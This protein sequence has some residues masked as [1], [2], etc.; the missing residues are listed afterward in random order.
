MRFEKNMNEQNQQQ[1]QEKMFD[2]STDLYSFIALSSSSS[3]PSSLRMR[4][5]FST[6]YVSGIAFMIVV[7]LILLWIN[8]YSRQCWCWHDTPLTNRF[9]YQWLIKRS[10]P[11]N[12]NRSLSINRPQQKLS[13]N[14][15]IPAAS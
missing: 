15:R 1:Q 4:T 13:S 9:N 5:V 11:K 14:N 3:S 2:N 8:L 12:I 10:V 6:V 7:F